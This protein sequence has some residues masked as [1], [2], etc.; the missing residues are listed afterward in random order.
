MVSPQLFSI[1]NSSALYSEPSQAQRAFQGTGSKC[2]LPR[3]LGGSGQPEG[4][5]LLPA[6]A[7]LAGCSGAGSGAR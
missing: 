5:S 4:A 7:L 1:S 3:P 6:K 2:Q